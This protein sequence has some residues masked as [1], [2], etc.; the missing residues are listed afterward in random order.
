MKIENQFF[1]NFHARKK[2]EK[3]EVSPEEITQKS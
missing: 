2:S 1:Y 3:S